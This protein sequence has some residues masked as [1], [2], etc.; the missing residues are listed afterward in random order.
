MPPD[1]LDQVDVRPFFGR[2]DEYNKSKF[3]RNSG[4]NPEIAA[5]YG[6]R[7]LDP[8]V[9]AIVEGMRDK[10]KSSKIKQIQTK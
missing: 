9:D 3:K 8:A 6:S 2:R 4:L 7:E 5:E 10:V 1:F